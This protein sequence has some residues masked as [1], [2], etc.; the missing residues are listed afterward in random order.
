MLTVS[1]D[2]GGDASSRA[3]TATATALWPLHLMVATTIDCVMLACSLIV[4]VVYSAFES[5]E[6][7]AAQE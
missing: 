7:N 4:E 5:F 3:A 1:S 2:G 6:D